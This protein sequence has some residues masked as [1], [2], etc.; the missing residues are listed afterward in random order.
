[1]T[2]VPETIGVIVAWDYL[3]CN[4]GHG[5]ILDTGEVVEV[6]RG[7][8][9]CLDAPQ[10]AT[11]TLESSGISSPGNP[12]PV[13]DGDLVLLAW[14]GSDVAWYAGARAQPDD[15][16]CPYELQ[17]AAFDAGDELHFSS[18]LLLPKGEGFAF[19]PAWIERP[20]QSM[21]KGAFFCLDR[22]GEV[23]LVRIPFDY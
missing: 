18:G 10:T 3:D 7:N 20:S 17:G 4:A 5:Y 14:N 15:P 1:M 6:F 21:P 13:E 11:L 22:T 16:T 12:G 2:L 9:T 23:I 8:V 19:E